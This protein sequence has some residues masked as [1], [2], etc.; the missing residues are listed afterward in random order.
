MSKH[1]WLE[2][3]QQ[4]LE[5][6]RLNDPSSRVVIVGIGHE[7]RGDDAAGTYM[8]RRLA[9][10]LQ[11]SE[12][13]LLVDAGPAPENYTS[14]LRRF[15]PDLVILIDAADMEQSPGSMQWIPWKDS[16]GFSAST[17]S[18]PLHIFA[19]YLAQELKC[20]ISLLGIQPVDT[21]L[22]ARLSPAVRN[23]VDKAVLKMK[24]LITTT[25]GTST[26]NEKPFPSS[27]RPSIAIG[28]LQESSQ[29]QI[30]S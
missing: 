18:L 19:K 27:L 2:I 29:E 10:S 22:D 16:I 6:L 5:R 21:S 25:L 8:I 20:E 12:M 9:S 30:R 3:L 13:L 4:T 7:L 26:T 11:Q 24:D 17:H 15:A 28:K 14:L 23:T 1:S